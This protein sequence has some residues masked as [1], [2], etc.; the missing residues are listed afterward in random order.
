MIYEEIETYYG[1]QDSVEAEQWSWFEHRGFDSSFEE[2]GSLI[3]TM[4]IV[5]TTY[6]VKG[7]TNYLKFACELAREYCRCTA[8]KQHVKCTSCMFS[9]TLNE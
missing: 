8:V 5:H 1:G 9:T 3:P 6:R 4:N 2:K 7:W